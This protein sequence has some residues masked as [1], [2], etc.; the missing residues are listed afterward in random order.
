MSDELIK[1]LNNISASAAKANS[2]EGWVAI[3]IACGDAASRI[4][5]QD[6][7]I[8]ELRAA[9]RDVWLFMVLKT[10]WLESHPEHRATIERLQENDVEQDN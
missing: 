7:E 6:R 8:A 10:Q 4:E 1:R 5:S 2:Y 9:L 3:E